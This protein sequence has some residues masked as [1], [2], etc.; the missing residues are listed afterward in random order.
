MSAMIVV[1]I[2]GVAL[3]GEKCED[4]RHVLRDRPIDG[5]QI[6]EVEGQDGGKHVERL[7]AL[8]ERC[9]GA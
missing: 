5:E 1:R 4:D 6:G 8:R 9:I 3:P 7:G 2:D